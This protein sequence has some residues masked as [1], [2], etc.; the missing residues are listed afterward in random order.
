MSNLKSI[1]RISLFRWTDSQLL[2][3]PVVTSFVRQEHRTEMDARAG[4]FQA[5]ELFGQQ[6]LQGGHYA[7][8]DIQD[9]LGAMADARQDLERW[10]SYWFKYKPYLS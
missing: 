8:V 5:L 9:K 7:S 6:L 2:W 10:V 1:F 4:T 3:N